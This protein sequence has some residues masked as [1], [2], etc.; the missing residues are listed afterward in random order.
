MVGGPHAEV[1]PEDFQF[2]GIDIISH[3]GGFKPFETI[4]TSK[5][6]I[7]YKKIKGISY[8][9]KNK[10]YKNEREIFD[11]TTLPFPDRTHFYNNIK[12]YK[13]VTMKSCA[14]LKTSYSCP[15]NCN[16]CFSTLLNG[17]KYL[18]REPNRYSMGCILS[19]RFCSNVCDGI[20]SC[21]VCE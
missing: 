9:K 19:G 17:G 2:E 13:Y 12:K 6:K 7:D 15:H 10:W 11:V 3:S 21:F 4:I 14:I 20:C 1:M 16:Y 18:C 8:F 5:K